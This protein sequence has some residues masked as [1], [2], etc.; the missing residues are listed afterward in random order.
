MKIYTIGGYSEVGKN[1]TVVE[2]GEDAFIFDMGLHLP[3]IVELEER[4]DLMHEKKL[5]SIG[6]VPDDLILD[7]LGIRNKVRAIL[8][9]HA[10]LDHVGAV[11]Y[12][13]NRYNASILAT[14]F[15]VAVLT[16]LLDDEDRQLYNKVKPITPNSSYT[17]KGKSGDYLV[18]F[19]NITHST[20][21]A[22]LIALHTREG[23]VLYANDFKFDDSPQLGLKPNYD[24]L[25]EISKKGVK[26]MIVESLY[27]AEERKTPSE[28][29]AR[30]LLEDVMLTTDNKNAGMIITTFSSHI[31]R[32]KSI[33]DFGKQLNR[34]IIFA[35]R[36][37]S[38]YVSAAKEI[39]LCP[40]EKSVTILSYKRQV[41]AELKKANA[42]KQKYLIVCTGH[43]GEP[44]SILDRMSRDDLPFHLSPRDHVIFSSKTI[45]SE[46]NIANKSQVDKR[47][48]H[49]GVRI[50]NDVHV[51]V[52]PSTEVVINGSNGMR[53]K[54]IGKIQENE[55]KG[56]KVPAF[57][58]NLKIKWFDAELVEHD[59]DGKIF[60]IHTK[61]G[62]KVSITSGHS[63]FKLE[64][65]GVVSE[66][67]DK[68]KVGDYLAIPKRFSWHSRLDEVD[69]TQ[70]SSLTSNN[71]STNSGSLC[72]NNVPI[73]P[74]KIKLSNE[75]ARLL[76]YYLAEGSAPRH[77][78]LVINKNET[79]LLEDIKDSIKK[80]LPSNIN[81]S[82]RNNACEICFGAE[83]L[84]RIFK[85]W[86]GNN[87][88]T[89]K[90]PDF[91][92]SASDEF[93]LNF[94]GAYLNGDGCIDKGKKHFRIRAKT[95]SKKL[96]S[97]LLY[98]FS[99]VGICAKFDHEETGANRMIAGNKM[100]TPETHAFVIR[101]QGE[102]SL[103]KLKDYLSSKFQVQIDVN[104]GLRKNPIQ[105]LPPESLPVEKLNFDEIEA[106]KGTYLHDI[107]FYNQKSQKVKKHISP[108]LLLKQSA[109]ISGFTNKI[110]NGELLFDP[111]VD[112]KTSDYAGKVYDFKVPGAQN[113]IGGFGGIMLHN[114][115][116][117]GREDLRDF[118]T[119]LNPEN[120]IPAHG[121]ITK[122]SALAEL[123]TELGFRI[124]KNCHI[125]QDL[126]KID[127]T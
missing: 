42:N 89:K 83:T 112:I 95:A 15:T 118:I 75:F 40:F 96:T 93:K 5:R 24:K 120:I 102:Q 52:T 46:I 65:G 91:V 47:L 116:H 125:S 67:G 79:E 8:I 48:K 72:Y 28:K 115:G 9:S 108:E 38:K 4:E 86:F 101:V 78:S 68:L 26:V 98:L 17:I 19:I 124:G 54:E 119:M 10:H 73:C 59:Y 31:A 109:K 16:R 100:I 94:I 85:Q 121:D 50:F 99:Q 43:Q 88:K 14:P 110:L 113:F 3:P 123:A 80:V 60:D 90:I 114:S 1:M 70:Y 77:L 21:Q 20:L 63:V 126:N 66:I 127:I 51:S 30:S 84:G 53:I 58:S 111:I 33:V 45:P 25:R 55:K 34:K 13:S 107:K 105:N 82:Y 62:R 39:K 27:A 64:K 117:A 29:V 18:E 122:L 57:D 71:Y 103:I 6:A 32:L 23:I 49:K 81:I 41:E 2:T 44:G 11:P 22:S 92:F 61:S 36:S 35:G 69:M 97:D 76:G 104:L 87:A 12:I 56:L 74:V 37:L 7:K 106:K